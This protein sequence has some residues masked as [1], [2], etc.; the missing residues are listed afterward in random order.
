MAYL[1]TAQNTE[2]M[3]KIV[4]VMTYFERLPQLLVT[5]RS[6]GKSKYKNFEVIIVDDC[7]PHALAVPPQ[8]YPVTVLR[9]VN[10][11]WTNPE[12]AYNMGLYAGML[13]NPDIFILQNAEC[14]HVG[15]VISKA[16]E[17]TDYN[18]ISFGCFSID[19]FFTLNGHDIT[20]LLLA[21][22]VGAS[23]DGQ[24]AWYN[25]PV[26]RPVGYD[27]CSA[28]TTNNIVTL[29]GYDEHLSYGCGYGDD[30]LLARIK[31]LGIRV[32]IT[33]CPLVVH[34]WH[35]GGAVPENKAKLVEHNRILYEQLVKRG[36]TRAF[37]LITRDL[38]AASL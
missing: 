5:L 38:C 7:S 3:K 19:E 21:N 14:Y 6:I 17:V 10:K 26:Y 34:Q 16:A 20:G 27:F 32:D 2:D 1:L 36:D 18:Y 33:E 35:Y 28:I 30:Y 22:P 12:P 13:K 37:H 29:N 4:I 8:P 9:T 11:D 15:D 31:M 24:N 25:H 23:R